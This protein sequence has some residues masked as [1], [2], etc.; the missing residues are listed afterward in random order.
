[1]IQILGLVI[2]VLNIVFALLDRNALLNRGVV[3]PFHWGWAFLGIVYPIGRSVIVHGV[4]RPRG[5]VPIWVLI[6]TYLV[7]TV[8]GIVA[9]VQLI[10]QV[11]AILPS[12]R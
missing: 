7:S 8:I 5:L 3:R 6:G 10:S 9:A 11:M 2:Y 1:M 4:A 12:T